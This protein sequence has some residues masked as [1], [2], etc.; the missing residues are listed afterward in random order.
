MAKNYIDNLSEE[1]RKGMLEKAEQGTWP[2]SAPIGYNN[3]AGADG[4]RTIAVDPL[5]GSVVTKLFSWYATGEFSIK[6]LTAKA[7]EAGLSQRRTGKPIPTS[8]I[9]AL[10]QKRIYAG[11]FD[12][13]G[14]MYHGTH[15]PLVSRELFDR[16]RQ[17]LGE[18][19]GKKIRSKRGFA[20]TGLIAC[21]HCGCALVGDRKKGRYVYYR[22]THYKGRCPEFYVREET[23]GVKF[24]QAL[25]R[26]HFGADTLQYLKRALQESRVDQRKEHDEAIKGL[27]VEYDRLQ[28]RL[29]A[30]YVDKIDGTVDK[31][32][33]EKLSKDWRVEQSRC[34][35]EIA[36]HQNADQAYM[37]EGSRLLDLAQNAHKIFGRQ[38]AAQQQRMLKLLLS[39]STWRD[40]QLT[41]QWRQ[42][43]DL[44]E[45]NVVVA[46]IESAK[47][48]ADFE[49]S[50]VWRSQQDS[51]LQPTE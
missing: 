34:L 11:D 6:E 21:G 7:G 16:V 42:P 38:K 51:N 26:L 10:L 3:V 36:R 43:F 19:D 9:H 22:C 45:E 46:A 30:L 39:N 35:E 12:W 13:K 14:R 31:A 47:L 49:P 37:T 2:S 27:Q 8:T 28:S 33:F 20:F 50:T 15:E 17:K 41:V 5:L 32:F 23:L 25:T 24:S 44:I 40:G 48:G 29:Q 1:A 4:K 18:R